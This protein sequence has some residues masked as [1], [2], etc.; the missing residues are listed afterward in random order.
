MGRR[1]WGLLLL[2]FAGCLGMLTSASDAAVTPAR[3]TLRLPGVTDVG[4]LPGALE[5]H[6]RGINDQGNAVGWCSVFDTALAD[7]VHAVFWSPATGLVRVDPPVEP[8]HGEAWAINNRNQVVVSSDVVENGTARRRTFLMQIDARGRIAGAQ[9]IEPPPGTFAMFVDGLN[10]QGEVVGSVLSEE[11]ERVPFFWSAAAGPVALDPSSAGL[12]AAEDINDQREVAGYFQE[13]IFDPAVA[14]RVRLDAQGNIVERTELQ[15]LLP[16][17]DFSPFARAF[18]INNAGAAAGD[19]L[20]EAGEGVGMLWTDPET[21]LALPGLPG[22]DGSF[23]ADLNDRNQVIGATFFGPSR[24]RWAWTEATGTL[25]LSRVVGSTYVHVLDAEEISNRGQIA[26]TGVLTTGSQRGLILDLLAQDFSAQ[27]RFRLG[28]ARPLGA[29][30]VVQQLEVRNVSRAVVTGPAWIALG[31]LSGN[32]Q[33]V[34]AAG[35]TQSP[36]VGQPYLALNLGPD[37]LLLPGEVAQVT[38]RFTR[39]DRRPVTFQPRLLAGGLVP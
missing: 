15:S 39:T 5:T 24:V 20:D 29:N 1:A 21:P 2:A 8:P 32:A 12:S 31:R 11:G 34:N 23:T 30:G 4:A 3:P 16:P 7:G 36:P 33:L 9:E 35:V 38:L 13:D 19:G 18:A 22:G 10:N 28:A 17:P 25:P 14:L 27:A 26:A 6:L 37:N